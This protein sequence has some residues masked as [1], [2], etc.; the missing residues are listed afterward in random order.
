MT[1]TYNEQI[2]LDAVKA[3]LSS[4]DVDWEPAEI[5]A[6][7]EVESSFNPRAYRN[8]PRIHDA[9]YGLMQ[10]LYRNTAQAQGFTGSATD[11]FRPSVSVTWGVK[12]LDTVWEYLNAHFG[13]EPSM[14]EVAAAYNAGAGA[15]AAHV[16]RHGEG[17]PVPDYV[18][19]WFAA[20]DRWSNE[21]AAE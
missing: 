6:F 2:A 7:I 10:T 4:A 20:Y 1:L 11:L 5:M 18:N 16:R 8:E 17:T 15:V 13:R 19:K 12:D 21:L 3:I 14:D 9:S